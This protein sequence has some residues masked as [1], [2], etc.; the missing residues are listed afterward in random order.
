MHDPGLGPLQRDSGG[1]VHAVDLLL[2]TDTAV[3]PAGRLYRHIALSPDGR[4]IVAEGYAFNVVPRAGLPADT[5]VSPHAA[6]W[7]LAAP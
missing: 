7:L 5:V 6:L 3:T 1:V 4:R 2:A